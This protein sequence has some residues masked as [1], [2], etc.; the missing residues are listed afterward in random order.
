MVASGLLQPD[1]KTPQRE[2]GSISQLIGQNLPALQTHRTISHWYNLRSVT[3]VKCVD[4]PS[5]LGVK[6]VISLQVFVV[7]LEL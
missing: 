2:T 4:R 1:Y 5:K 3:K 6:I 7:G